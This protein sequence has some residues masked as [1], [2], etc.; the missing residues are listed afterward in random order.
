LP[1]GAVER[2]VNG[3]ILLEYNNTFFEPIM[4]DGQDAYQVVQVN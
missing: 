2:E 1:A 3:E 4:Q